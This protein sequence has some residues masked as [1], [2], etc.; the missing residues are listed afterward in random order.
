MDHSLLFSHAAD[1]IKLGGGTR[2]WGRNSGRGRGEGLQHKPR[3]LLLIR[4]FVRRTK[5]SKRKIVDGRIIQ[6]A[7]NLDPN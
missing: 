4:T 3:D 6:K 2:G 1:T 5:G 7:A